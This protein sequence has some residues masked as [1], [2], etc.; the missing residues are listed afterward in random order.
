MD[1][2]SN[3]LK[4]EGKSFKFFGETSRD[5]DFV[6]IWE[7]ERMKIR[8]AMLTASMVM[9]LCD[10]LSPVVDKAPGFESKK[11]FGRILVW[12]KVRSNSRG[13]F[14]EVGCSSRGKSTAIFVPG[15]QDR[16]RWDDFLEFLRW[17][18][19]KVAGSRDRCSDSTPVRESLSTPVMDASSRPAMEE[20]MGGQ[21]SLCANC[22][23]CQPKITRHKNPNASRLGFKDFVAA[24]RGE[25]TTREACEHEACERDAREAL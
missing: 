14:L 2:T 6:K 23:C 21:C 15:V 22:A 24:V 4:I 8:H 7:K 1:P 17:T 10:S 19:I 25:T 16:H 9:W 12:A 18:A 20:P 11:Q 13:G 3:L 5:G